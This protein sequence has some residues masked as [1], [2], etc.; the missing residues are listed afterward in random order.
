[1]QKISKLNEENIRVGGKYKLIKKVGGGSFG[2]IYEGQDVES[3][4]IFAIKLEP[5]NTKYP[6][7]LYENKVLRI[8]KMG[9]GIPQ[10]H[11][12]GTDGNYNCLVMDMLGK[13][14]EQLFDKCKRK[15]TIKT[16]LMVGFQ[17]L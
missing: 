1:M 8:L 2:D 13:S 15:F 3:K 4:D 10:I 11:W 7:L 9:T 16:S 17:M 12:Y 5:Q 14:I 6:Q